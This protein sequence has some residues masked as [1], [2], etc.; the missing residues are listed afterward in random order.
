MCIFHA[1]PTASMSKK[2]RADLWNELVA[3]KLVIFGPTD[4]NE[5]T[6][7]DILNNYLLRKTNGFFTFDTPAA[8]K[9]FEATCNK[10]KADWAA[11]QI[12]IVDTSKTFTIKEKLP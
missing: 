5:S 6:K 9:T 11:H 3:K 7:L 1:H 8:D 4:L 10:Y 12:N 2:Q